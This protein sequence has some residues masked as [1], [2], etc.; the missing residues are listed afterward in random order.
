MED[1]VVLKTAMA[2]IPA[3]SSVIYDMSASWLSRPELSKIG[4][5]NPPT[6]TVEAI[7]L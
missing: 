3:F 5:R 7:D 4:V 1:L 2:K 6:Q